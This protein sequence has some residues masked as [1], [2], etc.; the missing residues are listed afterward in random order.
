MTQTVAG[1]QG[2]GELAPAFDEDNVVLTFGVMADA[3]VMSKDSHESSEDLMESMGH[4][5]IAILANTTF[6]TNDSD[7]ERKISDPGGK[8]LPKRTCAK[9]AGPAEATGWD[10]DRRLEH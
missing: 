9:G 3:H 6:Y 8:H 10:G 5:D 4:E 7:Q 1:T 2:A